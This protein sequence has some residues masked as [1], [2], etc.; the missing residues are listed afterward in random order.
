MATGQASKI[1]STVDYIRMAGEEHLVGIRIDRGDIGGQEIVPYLRW[2][3]AED[4]TLSLTLDHRFGI[5]LPP[6]ASEKGNKQDEIV[7]FIANAIAIGAGYPSIYYLDRRM[8][9][10]G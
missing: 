9:F 7:E 1:R 10:R 5:D 4:G 8:P 6:M 3:R 2:N